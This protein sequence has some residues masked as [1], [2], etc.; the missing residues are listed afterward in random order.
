MKIKTVLLCACAV[1]CSQIGLVWG[2]PIKSTVQMW[3]SNL[4]GPLGK[5]T[6][7]SEYLTYIACVDVRNGQYTNCAYDIRITGLAQPDSSV[8]NNG[9]HSPSTHSGTRPVG[10]LQ[11]IFPST[12]AKAQYVSGQ[13]QYNKVYVSHEMPEVSGKIETV[14]NLHVPPGW[15]TV[16]PES[17]DGKLR[18]WCF[19]VTLD[20]GVT[21]GLL[22]LAD[23]KSNPGVSF[24]YTRVRNA[25]GHPDEVA[26]YGTINTLF[27]LNNIAISYK[28]KGYK[29][30]VNDMSLPRGGLFDVD[31]DYLEPHSF[32][33]TGESADINQDIN[34]DCLQND[35]LRRAVDREMP[36]QA[37]S[38][39]A[40]AKRYFPSRFLCEQNNN[41][42]IH[43]DFDGMVF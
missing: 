8:S 34:G 2:A 31:A 1:L 13:T 14:F 23:P 4:I 3:P 12:G 40:N 6:A 17:C 15:Y 21:T 18:Y 33:R 39:F 22:P 11:E 32:H 5:P 20:V 35:L 24:S 41:N 37:G 19:Y 9:G 43:L 36:I 10:E 30:S 26:Y 38:P 7:K 16:Y 28:K 42:S 25:L 27:F 29:L